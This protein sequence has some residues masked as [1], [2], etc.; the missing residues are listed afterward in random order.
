M[1]CSVATSAQA[2]A[3]RLAQEAAARAAARR[4]AALAA[5]VPDLQAEVRATAA[6]AAHAAAAAGEYR[7]RRAVA[8]ADRDV[9]LVLTQGQARSGLPADELCFWQQT[10]V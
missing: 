9:H 4:L 2:R 10:C 8:A 7:Q 1:H 6:A 5:G 3:L